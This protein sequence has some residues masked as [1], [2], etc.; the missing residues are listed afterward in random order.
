MTRFVENLKVQCNII[1]DKTDLILKHYPELFR[2]GG[3]RFICGSTKDSCNPACA[4]FDPCVQCKYVD[5]EITYYTLTEALALYTQ[6]QYM[7]YERWKTLAV[8]IDP[9]RA[10]KSGKRGDKTKKFEVKFPH[11]IA[12]LTGSQ[13][14][15]NFSASKHLSPDDPAYW[16]EERLRACTQGTEIE[17]RM[18]ST[19]WDWSW[20][21]KS[22]AAG[23]TLNSSLCARKIEFDRMMFKKFGDDYE[24]TGV[25]IVTTDDEEYTKLKPLYNQLAKVM[26]VKVQFS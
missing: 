26:S 23:N 11:D 5:V 8:L 21:S 14:S 7:E 6:M 15:S 9:S 10:V 16:S 18:A 12:I 3:T 1:C 2:K 13:A 19:D 4:R 25:Y 20:Y 17:R 22:L 24:D